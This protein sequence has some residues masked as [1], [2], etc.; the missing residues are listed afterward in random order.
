MISLHMTFESI[1]TSVRVTAPW[2]SGEWIEG[3]DYF[4]VYWEAIRRMPR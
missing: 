3:P 2:L 1:G 4:T